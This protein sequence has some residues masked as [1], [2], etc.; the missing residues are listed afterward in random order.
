MKTIGIYEYKNYTSKYKQCNINKLDYIFKDFDIDGVDLLKK[1]L[2]FNPNER[3][4][5]TDA[6]NHIFFT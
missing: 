6:L 3:I 5:A 2:T 1:M 4:N